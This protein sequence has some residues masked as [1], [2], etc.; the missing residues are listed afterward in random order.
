VAETA[1]QAIGYLTYR[2]TA[3]EGEVLHVEVRPEWRRQG[4]GRALILQTRREAPVWHLEVRESNAAA[5]ALYEQLG[6][7]EVGRRLAYYSDGETAILLSW[8]L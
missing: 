5:R 8:G 7:V 2:V 3:G 4:V 6:F 1:G